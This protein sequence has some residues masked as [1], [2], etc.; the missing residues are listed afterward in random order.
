MKKLLLILLCLPLIGFGQETGCISGDCDNGVG[1]FYFSETEELY[2]WP[3]W[4]VDASKYIGE[5]KNKKRN[6]LGTSI[7]FDETGVISNIYIGEWKDGL[8]HGLGTMTW[9]YCKY[10]CKYEG[11]WWDGRQD[12]QG[13][14]NYASGNKYEGEYTNGRIHGYGTYTYADGS[15]EVGEWEAGI[16]VEEPFQE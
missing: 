1:I 14:M 5:W 10:E 6:G 13:T 2:G 12:G 4:V 9:Y 15:V 11:E 7:Y 3:N 16:F 8:R